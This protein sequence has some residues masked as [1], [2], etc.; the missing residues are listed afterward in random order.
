MTGAAR[1]HALRP[2]REDTHIDRI[3]SLRDDLEAQIRH[4]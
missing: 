3:F 4:C 2:L 1:W